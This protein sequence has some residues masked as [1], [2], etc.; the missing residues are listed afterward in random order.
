MFVR[1]DRFELRVVAD[2]LGI[3]GDASDLFVNFAKSSFIPI[4]CGPEVNKDLPVDLPCTIGLFPCTYLG[5]PLST[6]P[7]RK[8][9]LMKLADCVANHMPAW[10]GNLLFNIILIKYVLTAT[11]VYHMLSFDL[12][13]WVIKKIE[14]I[15]CD[16]LWRRLEEEKRGHCKI[17]WEMVY[18]PIEYG[19]LGIHNLRLLNV[20][21]RIRWLW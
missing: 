21:L 17:A 5:L 2:M 9:E 11:S 20:A 15:C 13:P 12:P 8:E 4:R 6:G 16:F 18:W 14:K 10:K 7:L 3:F 1:P 19:G